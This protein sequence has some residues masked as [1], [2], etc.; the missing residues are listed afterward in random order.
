MEQMTASVQERSWQPWDAVVESRAVLTAAQSLGARFHQ[1]LSPRGAAR[2]P[3]WKALAGGQAA[4]DL[5]RARWLAGHRRFMAGPRWLADAADLALWCWAAR[6]DPDT[7]EDAV[8][9]GVALAAEATARLGAPGLIVPLA[10]ATVMT[11]VRRRRGH[12]LRLEQISWQLMGS[13]GGWCIRALGERRQ[14][15][16][17]AH[18]D[19]ER[20]ARQ[21]RAE[22]TG[23]H[24]L[25][26]EHEGA[27][28]LLQRATTLIDLGSPAPVRQPSGRGLTGAIKA[29]AAEVAR[30]EATYLAEA[31]AAWQSRHNQRPD[32]AGVAY[33][34]LGPG[35]GLELLSPRQVELLHQRLDELDPSGRVAVSVT[36]A[37][38]PGRP[39]GS[40]HLE[41]GGHPLDLPAESPGRRWVLDVTPVAFLMDL[42]WLAQPTGS[43]RESVPWSVTGPPMVAALAAA[44]YSAR[45]EEANVTISPLTS[46]AVSGFLTLGYTVGA[47]RWMR[48]PHTADGVSRYPWVMALQ[49]YELVRGVSAERSSP[50]VRLAGRLG[51]G[52]I[53]VTGWRLSP[54]PRSARALV[55]E[56]GWVVGFDAYTSRLRRAMV[57]AEEHL[58]AEAAASWQDEEAAGYARG[59]ARARALVASALAGAREQLA[60]R[61]AD[62]APD[63]R[64]EA[65]RR[66]EEVAT[67]LASG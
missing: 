1:A 4:L 58:N 54:R 28:D 32:L 27:V 55:A 10:N 66:L 37:G 23:F 38:R 53:I 48:N 43:H 65:E 41:I 62:L 12:R 56:L 59:R 34:D 39:F 5:A 49:G 25:I 40:C 22:L 30:G 19:V 60:V 13:L 6:D 50:A 57:E 35:S 9:P 45:R 33:L 64:A 20:S 31:L 61:G 44:V 18:R 11:A 36:R 3:G 14:R 42:G 51:T 2:T 52:A 67:A 47:S 16:S 7:S 21:R 46:M 8:I 26:V 63:V 15:R 17:K 29:S 24:D